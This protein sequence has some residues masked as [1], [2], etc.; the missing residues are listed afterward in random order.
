MKYFIYSKPSTDFISYFSERRY[1]SGSLKLLREKNV[2]LFNGW[3]SVE[4]IS[5]NRNSVWE[6]EVSLSLFVRK[7]LREREIGWNLRRRA[8]FG[9][10][11]LHW[12]INS[13]FG[14]KSLWENHVSLRK[15]SL[16]GRKNSLERR[17]IFEL[18]KFHWMINSIW[19]NEFSVT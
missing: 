18:R 13:I 16:S 10:M 14:M 5:K 15:R 8:W 12:K 1:R 17:R 19:R 7:N 9:R 11:K 3:V 4:D 2:S 6:R